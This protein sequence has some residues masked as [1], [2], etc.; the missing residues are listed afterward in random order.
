MPT[1]KQLAG[2]SGVLGGWGGPGGAAPRPACTQGPPRAWQRREGP[3]EG[4][5]EEAMWV[6]GPNLGWL[7]EDKG[8]LPSSSLE[9]RKY[10]ADTLIPE[11][12]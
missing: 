12:T 7:S 4:Q 11:L 3:S 8:R 1:G 10:G 5:E 6:W 9:M 2:I